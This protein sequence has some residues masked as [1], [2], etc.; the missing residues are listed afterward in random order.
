MLV[1]KTAAQLRQARAKLLRILIICLALSFLYL[2]ILTLII[3]SFNESRMVTVWTHTSLKW[4]YALFENNAIIHAIGISLLV[5]LMTA[6]ASVVIGTLAA[7]V[8]VRVGRF[9]GESLFVLLMTAPMMLP[10]VITGLALLLIFVTLGTEIPFFADRGVVAIWIAHVTFCSAYTTVVIRSR[11]R[12]LDVS[13]EEAAMDLG[14]GPIKVFFTVILPAL[15]TSEVAAFL[16]AFTMSMDDLV[17]SSFIAGP[18]STTLPMLIFSSVRRGLSPEINALATIIVFI[19]SIFTF[20]AWLS[21]VKKQ[22][23]VKSDAAKA[24]KA[25]AIEQRLHYSAPHGDNTTF[26]GQNLSAEALA[27]FQAQAA[28]LQQGQDRADEASAQIEDLRRRRAATS[29]ATAA[30]TATTTA[31][32]TNAA[33]TTTASAV[34]ATAGNINPTASNASVSMAAMALAKANTGAG[35]AATTT[36]NTALGAM[37]GAAANALNATLTSA[38]TASE[39]PISPVNAAMSNAAA[40]VAN[41]N[42]S[43]KPN[44]DYPTTY[45]FNLATSPVTAANG[46]TST[47]NSTKAATDNSGNIRGML[48]GDSA[49][50]AT[51]EQ[52]AAFD[53]LAKTGI[54]KV[55]EAA[56]NLSTPHSLHEQDE[57]ELTSAQRQSQHESDN[58]PFKTT[59]TT[60]SSLADAKA[61][62][63]AQLSAIDHALEQAQYEEDIMP[64]RNGASLGSFVSGTGLSSKPYTYAPN[65]YTSLDERTASKS[66]KATT[67]SSLEQAKSKKQKAT[68]ND[69]SAIAVTKQSSEQAIAESDKAKVFDNTKPE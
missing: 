24:A 35:I 67:V 38:T 63:A 20:F 37:V 11:F 26:D 27:I 68:N 7:Y 39:S 66:L 57:Q 45:T 16:L 60:Q 61:K 17:V 1:S 31:T 42:I 50:A 54:A 29:N 55:V 58:K 62:K 65:K 28:A 30:A 21:M 15:L 3:Y 59:A 44:S 53:H 13:I 47:T 51:A 6:A 10:D 40:T 8:L 19:V 23:R 64:E 18:D 41:S 46:T 22:K 32:A 25:A 34:S 5:A 9:R 69:Q 56:T 36:T 49:R 52:R 43:S 48:L 12:E 14:A 4:Y 2:P 33:A